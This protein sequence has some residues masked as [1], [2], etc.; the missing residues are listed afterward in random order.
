MRR[1]NDQSKKGILDDVESRRARDALKGVH[2][3]KSLGR[4]VS[5]TRIPRLEARPEKKER[6]LDRK[7]EHMSSGE[8]L[9][10]S[11]DYAASNTKARKKKQKKKRPKR[12]RRLMYWRD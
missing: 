11:Q 1:D 2:C 10:Y 4:Q 3:M 5:Q 6:S 8:L 7:E 12:E 9:P